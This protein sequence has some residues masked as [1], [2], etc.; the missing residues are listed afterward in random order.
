[1]EKATSNALE[2]IRHRFSIYFEQVRNKWDE[3]KNE[4]E[5]KAVELKTK[6][7]QN[8]TARGLKPQVQNT[9][10]SHQVKRA[11]VELE[12]ETVKSRVKIDA[13]RDLDS[14]FTQARNDW[15][16]K[17]Q[18]AMFEL[19]KNWNQ[20]F[21]AGSQRHEQQM[22]ESRKSLVEEVD[23]QRKW[24]QQELRREVENQRDEMATRKAAF[25]RRLQEQ[26]KKWAE[27]KH[28]VSQQARKE[29]E[30]RH[31]LESERN[32]KWEADVV[33]HLEV[34]QEH[35]IEETNVQLQKKRDEAI[36][37]LIREHKREQIKNESDAKAKNEAELRRTKAAHRE[38]LEIAQH[39][40][41]NVQN[42]LASAKEDLNASDA[43]KCRYECEL[44]EQRQ[45]IES[46]QVENAKTMRKK[47]EHKKGSRLLEEQMLRDSQANLAEIESRKLQTKQEIEKVIETS[48]Q[49]ERYVR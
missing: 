38:S 25:I 22:F 19:K 26:R 31:L 37:A 40:L 18:E 7:I 15:E 35:Y 20:R 47:E 42:R 12:A 9:M 36:D 21:D 8:L 48:R 6:E 10:K 1:M 44:D 17:T 45:Q 13:Q 24:Q 41:E 23:A 28:G 39:Q 5:Q 16:I 30:K 33:R 34:E 43:L 2:S 29:I 27:E 46:L 32:K 49:S 3:G 14:S 11:E 4:R